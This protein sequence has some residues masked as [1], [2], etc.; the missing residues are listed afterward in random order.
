[1][2]RSV[3]ASQG[4]WSMVFGFDL[5][6]SLEQAAAQ[7]SP[8]PCVCAGRELGRHRR[9][10]GRRHPMCWLSGPVDVGAMVDPEHN[11][12]LLLVVDLIKH[13]V[14]TAPGRPDPRQFA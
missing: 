4:T 2:T 1:M 13:P 7:A 8:S 10:D 12:A 14:R 5:L 3:R 9:V 6:A 11:D